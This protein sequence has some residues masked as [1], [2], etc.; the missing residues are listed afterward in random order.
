VKLF[1]LIASLSVVLTQLNLSKLKLEYLKS[2][3][4]CKKERY[5]HRQI[6]CIT[7]VRL[8]RVQLKFALKYGHKAEYQLFIT[9]YV[10]I[11]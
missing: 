5:K 7:L 10:Q 9:N 3:F 2:G 4:Q 1:Q 6:F 8:F 11:Y